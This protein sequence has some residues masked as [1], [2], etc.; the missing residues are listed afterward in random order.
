[1]N[2]FENASEFVDLDNRKLRPTSPSTADSLTN[3]F[4]V[5]LPQN[6]IQGKRI[7]DLGSCLGAA[8]YWALSNGAKH[9]TGV[10]LQDYYVQT[11]NSLLSKY[12]KPE[13]FII[14]QKDIESFL[15]ETIANKEQYDYVLAAGILYG[16]FDVVG[17]LTKISLVAK[18]IVVIETRNLKK[19]T[20]PDFGFIQFRKRFMIKADAEESYTGISGNIN[21]TA[22]DMV[23]SSV[24]FKR[25]EDVLL[26]KRSEGLDPFHSIVTLDDASKGP[27]RYITRYY[28]TIE[29][30]TTLKDRVL[31]DDTTFSLK[32]SDM[33]PQ[34]QFDNAVAE[35]FQKEAKDHIPD[36]ERVVNLCLDIA[37]RH[38]IK[39]DSII[40]V[41]SAL[42]FT[43]DKFITAGFTNTTGVEKSANMISNSLHKEQVKLSETLPTGNY[44]MILVNWTL[45]FIQ[46]KLTYLQSVYNNLQDDGMLILTDK[47]VQD[48]LTKNLYYQFKRNNGVS[49]EY[50]ESKEQ[51]LVG[52]MHLE[53]TE[54]YLAQLKSMFK[55]VEIVNAHLG[56][57]TFVC[58]K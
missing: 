51:Q 4:E 15:E 36:Y 39:D 19:S 55:T 32:F 26:P 14:V 29:K 10:E 1:M 9:Y 35:R 56:F 41:G 58:K 45:H 47:T 24:S 11:S 38:C 7:L 5:E 21:L 53:T 18:D 2:I 40:D 44:K 43:I 57:V 25:T 13:Q 30:L 54:W 6:L 31:T 37:N 34:W 50:I 28:R 46:D 12:C 42:G 27:P 17:I 52:V 20:S 48:S 22:L 8:G 23:M 33:K 49:Q 3:K 16:F